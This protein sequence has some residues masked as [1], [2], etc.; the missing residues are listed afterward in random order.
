MNWNV[1]RCFESVKLIAFR[2]ICGE[3][4]DRGTILLEVHGAVV[5]VRG[6]PERLRRSALT[7]AMLSDMG[8]VDRV[9]ESIEQIKPTAQGL[10]PVRLEAANRQQ[11]RSIHLLRHGDQGR[12]RS[13]SAKD[14]RLLGRGQTR[15]RLSAGRNLL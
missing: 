7:F 1:V 3:V 14:A 4:G 5:A 9:A 15:E 13:P 6:D 2:V 12:V 10:N 11:A 8:V